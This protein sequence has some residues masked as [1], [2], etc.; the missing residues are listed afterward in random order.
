LKRS[1]FAQLRLLKGAIAKTTG[2]LNI[3]E[4]GTE[5]TTNNERAIRHLYHVAEAEYEDLKAFVA[6]FTADGQ[7]IDMSSGITLRGPGEQQRNKVPYSK[8]VRVNLPR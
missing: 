5:M 4:G 1:L 6:C 3:N 7:F 2:R 8:K